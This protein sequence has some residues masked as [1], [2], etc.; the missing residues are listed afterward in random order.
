VN[1]F[2]DNAFDGIQVYCIRYVICLD[3]IGIESNKVIYYGNSLDVIAYIIAERY[4]KRLLTFGTTNYD[5]DFLNEK[6][7]DYIVSRMYALFNFIEMNGR[8]FRKPK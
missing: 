2:L 7:G 5:I 8:D 6:Y 3:D 4:A 1:A